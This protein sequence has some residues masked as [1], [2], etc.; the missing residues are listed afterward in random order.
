ML[1]YTLRALLNTFVELWICLGS[2]F[3]QVLNERRAKSVFPQLSFKESP[4]NVWESNFSLMVMCLLFR[5]FGLNSSKQAHQYSKK[6]GLYLLM[7]ALQLTVCFHIILSLFCFA[8]IYIPNFINF[9][10]HTFVSFNILQ[11]WTVQYNQ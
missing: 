4:V 8:Q 7:M 9:K 3:C 10:I 5:G 1:L 2:L 6:I 11:N